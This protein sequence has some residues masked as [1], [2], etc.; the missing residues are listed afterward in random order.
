MEHTEIILRSRKGKKE[1][2]GRDEPN[3]GMLYTYTEM[4]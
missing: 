4:S 2:N 1:N 3:W